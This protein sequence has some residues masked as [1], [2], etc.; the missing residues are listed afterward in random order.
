ML[1]RFCLAA[2]LC[3][4]SLDAGNDAA[5]RGLA[6]DGNTVFTWADG[7]QRVRWKISNLFEIAA[8]KFAEGG[9]L[10]D[11]DGDDQLDLIVC[12]TA[13]RPALIWLHAPD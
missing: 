4:C 13:S 1:A 7:V 6:I 3:A 11:V 9:A 10:M 2:L 12:Q 5:N 8:G